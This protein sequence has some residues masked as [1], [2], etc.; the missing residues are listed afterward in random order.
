ME[1]KEKVRQCTSVFALNKT[2]HSVL[3][4]TLRRQYYT[5]LFFSLVISDCAFNC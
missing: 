1:A 2:A 3:C 5:I 4:D